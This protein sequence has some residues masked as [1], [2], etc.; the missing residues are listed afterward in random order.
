VPILRAGT[1]SFIA[2]L[3]RFFFAPHG[4]YPPSPRERLRTVGRV[5]ERSEPGWGVLVERKNAPHPQPLPT[6]P[7]RFAGGGENEAP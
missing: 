6:A 1:I 3:G 4:W 7:L 5:G 2:Q